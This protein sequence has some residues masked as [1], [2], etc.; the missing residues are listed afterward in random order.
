MTLLGQEYWIAINSCIKEETNQG[1]DPTCDAYAG[2]DA[3]FPV[4]YCEHEGGHEWP[5]FASDAL[6]TFF[7]NLPPA[8]PSDKT[9]DGDIENLGKGLISF[10][11]HYP[12][13]F[14]GKPDIIALAL[15]P[16]DTTPPIYDAPSYVLNFGF[17]PGEVEYGEIV[18]YNN[19]EMNLLGVEYGD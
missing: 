4:H 10:K 11:I 14:V 12:L 3:A 6:W 2:C 7:Q 1:V 13:D 9:G 15:Y 8:A 17:P 19:I 16:Y 5:D 18:E